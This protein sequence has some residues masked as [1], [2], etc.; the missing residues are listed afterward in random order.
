[1]NRILALIASLIDE[2]I[3]IIVLLIILPLFGIYLPAWFIALILAILIMISVIT[4]RALSVLKKPVVVG[5]EVLIGKIGEVIS[6]FNH[7]GLVYLENEVWTAIS[8]SGKINKGDK[9]IV[10]SIEG[11][12]LIVEKV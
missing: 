6:D 4:Y 12:K 1:M 8:K 5:K 11:T 3:F 9:V 10:R 7:E 2:F